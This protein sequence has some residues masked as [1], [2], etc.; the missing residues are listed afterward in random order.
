VFERYCQD[1][2]GERF[3]LHRSRALLD[4]GLFGLGEPN[5]RLAER[6]GDYTLIARGNHVIREHLPFETPFRQIGVHG[7]LSAAELMVP[8]CRM[9]C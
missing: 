2:L 6:I 7:G 3:Q 5:P 9:H 1:L 4:A 8:L